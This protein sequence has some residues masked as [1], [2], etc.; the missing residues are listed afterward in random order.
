MADVRDEYGNPIQLTDQ[1]GNPVQ[2]TDEKG[3]PMHLTGVA[4]TAATATHSGPEVTHTALGYQPHG[5]PPVGTQ[6][7]TDY[8]TRGATGLGAA[9]GLGSVSKA[10]THEAI[11]LGG[12]TGAA[13]HGG[14][15]TEPRTTGLGEVRHDEI[16]HSSSSSSSSSEDDGQG[17]RIKKKKGLREKIKDKLSGGSKHKEVEEGVGHGHTDVAKVATVTTTATPI[18]HEKKSMMEKIKEKL[19]GH[20]NH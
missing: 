12:G 11:G 6:T 1:H 9:V 19:P 10:T 17:G 14:V 2:L 15:S 4:T 7:P 5:G 13:A 3:T 18:E 16:Q 8:G 20:H